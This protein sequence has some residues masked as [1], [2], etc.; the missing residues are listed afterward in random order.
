LSDPLPFSNDAERTA[1]TGTAVEHVRAG[2]WLVHPTETVYGIG[3][4]LDAGPLRALAR[5]KRQGGEAPFLLVI[6]AH[7]R[8]D[9]LLWTEA[10]ERLSEA[11]WPG[12]LTMA[13]EARPG[14][15]PIEVT[16]S[17]G[18]VAIRRS[19]HPGVCAIVDALDAPMTS[20]SA[21][22]PGAEP[23]RTA[24][25]AGL[26]A[27]ALDDAVPV[28]VLDGG[29]LDLSPPSTVVLAG[30]RGVRVLRAGAI[31]S[32]DVFRALGVADVE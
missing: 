32:D 23:A 8:S 31:P 24:V 29:T 18:C 9:S 21:N 11:F 5:A 30:A 12:P 28:L 27:R 25:E 26:A 6:P 16:S 4:A 2:G 14:S 22:L 19:P 17:D 7:W 15:F 13:L 20:T 3:C 10:A 1:A